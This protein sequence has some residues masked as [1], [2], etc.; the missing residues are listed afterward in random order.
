VIVIIVLI[1][2]SLHFIVITIKY[3]EENQKL[4]GLKSRI[5][6]EIKPKWLMKNKVHILITLHL[7]LIKI[8]TNQLMY[9]K[10]Y[11]LNYC[12]PNLLYQHQD[13]LII[14]LFLLKNNL[15]L[16]KLKMILK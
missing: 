5:L 4:E 8:F 9:S 10:I 12:H 1:M 16:K 13:R 15:K 2:L 7:Y 11:L 14:L 6:L 3:Q